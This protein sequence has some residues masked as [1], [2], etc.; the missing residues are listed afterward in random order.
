MTIREQLT[1]EDY[2]NCCRHGGVALI[3]NCWECSA[4]FKDS[5]NNETE[6]EDEDDN[7]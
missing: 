7:E 4:E 6:N 3:I 5:D 2:S 1:D